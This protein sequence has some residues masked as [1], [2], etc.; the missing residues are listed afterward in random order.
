MGLRV[1]KEEDLPQILEMSL[2]FAKTTSFSADMDPGFIENLIKNLIAGNNTIILLHE[3]KGF[4]AGLVTPFLFGDAKVATE[5]AW[6]VEPKE[7]KNG[8]GQELLEA[9]EYW[10]KEM[11]CSY[12]TMV[13]LDHKLGKL[14]T[15]NG[16]RIREYA[17]M[18]EI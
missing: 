12:V 16:Y 9:F 14:Y 2:K 13:S 10:A 8:V 6:W 1:A 5:I 15:K 7:R 17:Y 11:N 4:I 18:K 3:N